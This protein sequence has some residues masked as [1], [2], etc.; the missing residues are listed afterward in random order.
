MIDPRLSL[1]V[2]SDRALFPASGEAEALAAM[3]RAV[4]RALA[5][6][7]TAAMLREKDLPPERLAPTARALRLATR[8]AR[9]LFIVNHHLGL[10]AQVGAD[11]VHL[12]W[13]SV[14]VAEARGALGPEA[15]IGVSAH[16]IEELRRAQAQGA[17]YAT[18]GPVFA[19]P[20]KAGLVETQGTDALRRAVEAVGIPV[21][22]LGGMNAENAGEAATAGAAG[23]AMIRGLLAADDPAEA[24]RATRLSLCA[25]R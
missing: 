13:R 10:A 18:F 12:G 16:S 2:V 24:A 15:M 8:R 25:P 1:I 21:V 5:G 9:A 23:V 7:A 11:G 19:T 4:E 22:A 6:G 3:T 14:S 17:D 20:S